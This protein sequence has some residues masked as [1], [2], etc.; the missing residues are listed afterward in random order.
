ML[1]ASLWILSKAEEKHRTPHQRSLAETAMYRYKQLISDKLNLREYNG[2][3][4]K[5]ACVQGFEQNQCFRN[6]CSRGFLVKWNGAE[7]N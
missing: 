3:T 5:S 6:T 4:G 7:R 1:D 2:Q